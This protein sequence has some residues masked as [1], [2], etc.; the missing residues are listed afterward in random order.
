MDKRMP[1]QQLKEYLQPYVGVHVDY[2]KVFRTSNGQE[3]ECVRPAETFKMS[4]DEDHLMVRLGR[5][6][7]KGECAGKVY[8]LDIKS[9]EVTIIIIILISL[10]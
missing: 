3:T 10:L 4:R 8:L 6:L 7:R 1:V 2:F 5:A 9:S